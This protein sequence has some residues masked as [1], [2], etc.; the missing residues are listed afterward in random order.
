MRRSRRQR[1]TGGR[2][3][4]RHG[5]IRRCRPGRGRIRR[6][7]RVGRQRCIGRRWRGPVIATVTGVPRAT[8]MTLVVVRSSRY[9]KN[10][11]AGLAI[12]LPL[13]DAHAFQ[14]MPSAEVMRLHRRGARRLAI[15]PGQACPMARRRR[16]RRRRMCRRWL[17]VLAD[18]FPINVHGTG[19]VCR[20]HLVVD[21]PPRS[22]SSHQGWLIAARR[23]YRNAP[24]LRPI[25]C[26]RYGTDSNPGWDV[27]VDQRLVFVPSLPR[28]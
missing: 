9:W 13:T 8:V 22:G 11:A 18:T 4:R 1:C 7:R 27:D 16:H 10:R 17:R 26:G 24:V 28:T 5:C 12:T 23:R 25:R 21:E 20:R 3:R 14:V 2:C 6:Q 19:A 15:I